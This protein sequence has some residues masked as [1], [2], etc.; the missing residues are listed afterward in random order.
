MLCHQKLVTLS[1]ASDIRPMYIPNVTKRG[2]Q[3]SR[4]VAENEHLCVIKS[5][6]KETNY[7]E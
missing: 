6:M 3:G 4:K 7:V 5:H 2:I 1:F